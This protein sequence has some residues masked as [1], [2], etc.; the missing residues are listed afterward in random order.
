MNIKLSI[1]NKADVLAA[2]CIAIALPAYYKIKYLLDG[3]LTF[4]QLLQPSALFEVLYAFLLAVILLALYRFLGDRIEQLK[5]SLMKKILPIVMLAAAVLVA[6]LFTRFFFNYVLP[7]GTQASFE[8]DVALLALILP[9]IISGVGE[10]IFLEGAKKQAE[11][12]ALSAKYEILKSRLSPHFL[13]NSLNT[14]VDIIEEDQELAI[15]FI[16]EMAA[17]YRYILEN[18]D[19]PLVPLK[20]EVDAIKSVIYLH[21]IRKPGSLIV[22]INTHGDEHKKI[23]PMALQT[24]V[25]NALKH[26]KYSPSEPM[27]LSISISNELLKIENSLNPRLDAIS[28]ADGLDNLNRRVAHI[29][30]RK[31]N[32]VKLA[33][34][35][36]V[37]V[38][39]VTVAKF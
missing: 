22:E 30:N 4:E 36:K 34:L 11:Q 14:L 19:Q 15:K 38:P 16:E 35:F 12:D 7:W 39:L 20:A 29:C 26:N 5:S 10:R 9:L 6:I 24:L 18:R 21:E 2:I 37:E 1:R 32:I 3:E 27:T 8:F 28:T 25:E 23:V 31:L 17:I 33:K 13:F